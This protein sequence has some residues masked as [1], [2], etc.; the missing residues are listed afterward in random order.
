MHLTFKL[1]LPTT[2][3][4]NNVKLNVNIFWSIRMETIFQRT[5]NPRNWPKFRHL[6]RF[7]T[8]QLVKRLR[9]MLVWNFSNFPFFHKIKKINNVTTGN[10]PIT[11]LS[12]FPSLL[13][14]A[15]WQAFFDR[16]GNYHRAGIGP[17][18]VVL[19]GISSFYVGWKRFSLR[20]IDAFDDS[21][22]FQV[23]N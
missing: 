13:K 22:I 9:A 7:A 17:F 15:L 8:N 23:F 2:L 16:S 20:F 4:I 18:P 1:Y 6:Q 21:L 5:R 10:G 19:P 3:H 14:Y 12:T 11:T